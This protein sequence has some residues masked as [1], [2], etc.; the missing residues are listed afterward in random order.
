MSDCFSISKSRTLRLHPRFCSTQTAETPVPVLQNVGAL[1]LQYPLRR[2]P[3]PRTAERWVGGRR[4]GASSVGRVDSM[5]I[6]PAGDLI[7]AGLAELAEHA[8]AERVNNVQR[9][10]DGWNSG[11]E[12]Y[13]RP[14]EAILA[15]LSGPGQ[16]VAVGGITVCPMVDGALRM[17][18][19]YVH[20]QW[21][22][23]GVG[24]G[25]AETLVSSGFQ[26]AATITCNAGATAEA[27]RFWEAMGFERV[28]TPGVTHVLRRGSA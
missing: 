12:R 21:R 9:I 1:E 15:A 18:R 2:N 17:R 25:L 22:R 24:R 28:D 16:V 3:G 10:F 27:P 14:G 4:E 19:F 11:K 23:R 20:P 6:R 7:P 8:A 13:D 5:S 26:V